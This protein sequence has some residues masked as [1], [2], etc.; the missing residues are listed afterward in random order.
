MWTTATAIVFYWHLIW[1]QSHEDL[2]LK[3]QLELHMEKA[4]DLE[5]VF[6]KSSLL[7]MECLKTTSFGIY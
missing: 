7:C 6:Q 1:L 5:E 2:T 3:Q 4:Q